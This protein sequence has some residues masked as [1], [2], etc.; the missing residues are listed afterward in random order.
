MTT[1]SFRRANYSGWRIAN[2]SEFLEELAMNGFTPNH[3]RVIAEHVTYRYSDRSVAPTVSD[4][5]AVGWVSADGVDVVLVEVDGVRFRP[6]GR[7]YHVTV[8]LGPGCQ[9]K[10][11][12]LALGEAVR[13]G[14]VLAVPNIRIQ[15]DPF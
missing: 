12:N 1:A 6:D 9:P 7:L 4:V 15:T 3:A 5:R 2:R 14:S 13:T 8:S 10:D 11:S